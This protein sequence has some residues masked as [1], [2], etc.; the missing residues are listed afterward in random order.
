[1]PV[2][3]RQNSGAGTRLIT[4]YPLPYTEPATWSARGQYPGTGG[5]AQT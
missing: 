2:E 3:L 5:N 1:L 4:H